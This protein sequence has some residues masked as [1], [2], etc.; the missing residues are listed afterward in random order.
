MKVKI[1][2]KKHNPED[3]SWNWEKKNMWSGAKQRAELQKQQPV[4]EHLL[5][6]NGMFVDRNAYALMESYK[7]SEKNTHRTKWAK[8]K[9]N[10]SCLIQLPC[11]LC[12]TQWNRLSVYDQ[13]VIFNVIMK[14]GFALL[15][16][17][18][19][20]SVLWWEQRI[21]IYGICTWFSHLLIL[22]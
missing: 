12:I 13:V 3:F 19:H 21:C 6:P 22:W 2:K 1:T 18:S 7:G 9:T 10:C 16:S 11:A 4:I 5:L 15:F 20:T 17:L 8:L 14:F